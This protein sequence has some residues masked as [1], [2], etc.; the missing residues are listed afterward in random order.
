MR[1]DWRFSIGSYP[2]RSRRRS[3][4]RCNCGYRRSA[5]DQHRGSET[6]DREGRTAAHWARDS[7]E[8]SLKAARPLVL[9]LCRAKRCTHRSGGRIRQSEKSCNPTAWRRAKRCSSRQLPIRLFSIEAS[10]LAA[11]VTIFGEHLRIALPGEDGPKDLHA[12]HAVGDKI[13]QLQVICTSAF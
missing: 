3:A 1:S 8:L 10:E 5:S 12:C 13:L 6:C 7:F 4:K 9:R 11:I 2:F